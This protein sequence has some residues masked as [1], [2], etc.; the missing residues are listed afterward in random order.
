MCNSA[1][2]TLDSDLDQDTLVL[3]SHEISLTHRCIIS[4]YLQIKI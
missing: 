2:L 1:Q 3:G 4:K